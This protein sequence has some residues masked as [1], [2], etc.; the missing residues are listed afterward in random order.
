MPLT[1]S[2]RRYLRGLAQSLKPVITIGNKGVTPSLLEELGTSLDHH[3]LL[4]VRLS[5]GDRE[6]REAEIESLLAASQ[7]ELVHRVGHVAALYRPNPEQPRLALP[8]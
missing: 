7:A 8:R 3:E 6:T 4:K 1:A 5:G 2:Q